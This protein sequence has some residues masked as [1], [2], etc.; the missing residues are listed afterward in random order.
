MVM[1]D[2]IVLSEGVVTAFL[3]EGDDADEDPAIWH[4]LHDDGV[5]HVC[6]S[7]RILSSFASSASCLVPTQ[8][9]PQVMKKI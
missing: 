7:S 5:W 9:H 2:E 4:V 6:L 8:T 3:P 1:T